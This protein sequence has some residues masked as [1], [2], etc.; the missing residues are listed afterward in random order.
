MSP[1][2]GTTTFF[3][4][5][6]S[7]ELATSNEA[8]PDAA[9]Q[10]EEITAAN[11]VNGHYWSRLAEAREKLGDE[12]GAIAAY[13]HVFELRNGFPAETAYK[14]ARCQARLGN[15]D[16]ALR[17]LKRA[18]ELGLR[19][20]AGAR[21]DDD[22]APLRSTTQFRELF[23]IADG[24]EMERIEG[25]RFDLNFL[26]REIK[27]RAFAP[28]QYQ[29]EAT[30][31]AAVESLLEEIPDLTDAQIIIE[32]IRLIMPLGDGHARIRTP[33]DRSDLQRAAPVQM[34]LFE[35]GL[36][37]VAA[38][39]RHRDL[40]GTRLVK[41]G[42]RTTDDV[43]QTV[44]EIIPRDNDNTYWVK[45][46][47]PLML[48]E[49]PI[50]HALGVIEDPEQAS[51]TIEDRDGATR[52]VSIAADAEEPAG[53][54][55]YAIPFPKGWISLQAMDGNPLPPSLRN[56]HIPYWFE[57]LAEHRTVYFQ[58]NS[59]RNAPGETLGDFTERL[60]GF[61]EVQDVEKLIVDIRWNDGGNTF[62]E[63]PLLRR[64]VGDPKI[65]RRGAL[66]II[67][68]RRTFSAAQNGVNFL[69]MHSEAIFVG[70]PTGSSPSFIGETA[71]F[72]LPYSKVEVNV[73]DLHW[74]GT[75]P[76][77]YRRWIA[78]TLLT[79]PT[80]A[81]YRANRDEAMEAILA[82]NEYLPGG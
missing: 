80:F 72:E 38:A 28:F 26:A 10:W 61:I 66:F 52:T 25:W 18:W 49:F 17:W 37:I 75:W 82:Y 73:S 67:I 8:W 45:E 13:E 54:L 32:M 44:S 74:V 57:Y 33:K 27:R 36:Y 24:E 31:D 42:D 35:E 20:V 11:P 68:G 71:M 14:I 55:R 7:A 39:P 63:L 77:D 1:G 51:L 3:R 78:P 19:D 48:R 23:G 56:A 9:V 30:F 64:I 16:E 5:L 69:D 12:H 40:I 76:G 62:L 59:V 65:N 21:E 41:I 70:E 60:F 6:A 79:P 22:L 53:E 50:L 43:M 47:L 2:I 46:N 4:A 34:Y 15:V 81:A 29:S 58:F